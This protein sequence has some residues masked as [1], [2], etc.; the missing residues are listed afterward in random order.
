MMVSPDFENLVTAEV[1]C[2]AADITRPPSLANSSAALKIAVQ[3]TNR[4][5]S[6]H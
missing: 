2:P 5:S 6:V 4:G 1:H 3:T